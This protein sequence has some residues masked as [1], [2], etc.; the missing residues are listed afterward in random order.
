MKAVFLRVVDATDKGQALLAAIHAH[1]EDDARRI[2][3]VDPESFDAVPR[4]PFVYYVTDGVRQVFRRYPPFDAPGRVAKQGLATGDDFRFVRAWWEPEAANE[5]S[6]WHPFLKGG[7]FS[8]FYADT[9][10]V[11]GYT[12]ADQVGILAAGNFNRGAVIYFKPGITWP[13]RPSGRGFFSHVPAGCIFSVMGMMMTVPD[14][15]HWQMLAI[16]NSRAYLGLLRILMSRGGANSGQTAT[17]EVGYVTSVPQPVPDAIV[18]ARLSCLARAAWSTMH[19]LDSRT[20]NSHAFVLPALLQMEGECLADR[21]A[22]WNA[23]AA[24]SAVELAAVQCEIDDLCFGLYGIDETD[25]QSIDE[26]FYSGA[27]TAD[28]GK[29]A[30][31]QGPGIG[32]EVVEVASPIDP[33]ILAAELVSWAVGVAFGRFDIREANRRPAVLP[34]ADPFD[35]LPVCSPGMLTGK[36]GLPLDDAP[37]DYPVE[38]PA[39]GV[40][41]DDP[42]DSRDLAAAVQHVFNAVFGANADDWWNEVGLLL[43]SRGRGLRAWLGERFSEQHIRQYS[44]SRRRAPILW[45]LGVPSGLYSVWLYAHRLTADTLFQL[46]ADVIGPK[47]SFEERTLNRLVQ[48]TEGSPSASE[49]KDIAGQA[50][51]VNELRTMLGETRRLAPL[52][53]PKLDD[54]VVLTMAPLW[55][56]VPH[57]KSWQKE[58]KGKWDE[59]AAGEYDWSH[60]AMRLWPD[61]VVHKCAFERSLAIA[62]ELESVF[63]R[64]AEAGKWVRREVGQEVIDQLIRERTSAAVATALADLMSA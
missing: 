63:W 38:F 6:R 57:N 17:F 30:R 62:H 27:S 21:A 12:R 23:L 40:L 47:L 55:R 26:L 32:Q 9:T 39:N 20:E 16:L 3:V 34:E 56:L 14:T 42:G 13:A 37:D 44:T 36:A 35:P 51:L 24:T 61:R 29:T 64:E 48:A 60:T 31:A 53:D 25:R 33:A 2:F 18:G 28:V 49:S 43:D 58:L 1:G 41:V 50:A 7:T 19:R 11:I 54:G 4:S 10:L 52:W 22:A 45:Q 5:E 8:P 46:Q 15:E 59:L